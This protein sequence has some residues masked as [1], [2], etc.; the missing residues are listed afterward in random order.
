MLV[1]RGGIEAAEEMTNEQ[2]DAMAGGD[3]LRREACSFMQIKTYN[4]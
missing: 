2:I 1:W 4:T 3:L